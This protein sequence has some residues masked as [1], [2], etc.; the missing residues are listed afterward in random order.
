[1][2][3]ILASIAGILLGLIFNV[4]ILL[5]VIVVG[6]TVYAVS[7]AG[8]NPGATLLAIVILSVSVQAGYMIGLT[9]PG[10]VLANSCTAQ[11]HTIEAGLSSR[12]LAFGRLDTFN[13]RFIKSSDV[14]YLRILA[15]ALVTLQK[16]VVVSVVPSSDRPE[17]GVEHKFEHLLAFSL[18]GLVFTL[19]YSWQPIVLLRLASSSRYY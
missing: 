8:Q 9:S 12:F 16:V 1:M 18:V 2:L 4:T 13:T 11:S 19:A 15:W 6:A 10:T 14:R 17:T 3:L 5:P 7:F